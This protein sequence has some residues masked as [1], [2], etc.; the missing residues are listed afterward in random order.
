MGELSG[1]ER[2]IIQLL[3]CLS[4]PNASLIILDESFSNINSNF[5]ENISN[6]LNELCKSAIIIIVSH[7]KIENLNPIMLE[8]E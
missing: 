2:Q 7:R 3:V 8:I 6:L 1:G 5:D 4:K